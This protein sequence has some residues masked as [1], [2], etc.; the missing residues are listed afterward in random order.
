[1]ALRSQQAL[2]VDG[3]VYSVNLSVALA[4]YAAL[5]RLP[6]NTAL[7]FAFRAFPPDLEDLS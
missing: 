5:K 3:L 6:R 4:N 2:H 7:A 1:M